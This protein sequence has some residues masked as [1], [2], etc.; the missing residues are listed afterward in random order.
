MRDQNWSDR[1]KNLNLAKTIR[2]LDDAL[3]FIALESIC[4]DTVV[5]RVNDSIILPNRKRFFQP[6]QPVYHFLELSFCRIE[7]YNILGRVAL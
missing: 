2:V 3:L 7:K 1:H 6:A 4:R 5:S